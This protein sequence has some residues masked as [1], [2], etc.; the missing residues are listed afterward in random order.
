MLVNENDL[1]HLHVRLVG[2]G[3]GGGRR[4]RFDR[5]VGAL[6]SYF[7]KLLF[8]GNLSSSLLTMEDWPWREVQTSSHSRQV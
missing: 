4:R 6:Y 5:C 8:I 3:G 1:Q 7:V 2:G